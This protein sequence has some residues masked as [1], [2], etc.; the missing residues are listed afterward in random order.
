MSAGFHQAGSIDPVI[1]RDCPD[2]ML[3]HC[4]VIN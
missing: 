3:V 4:I 1:A 2:V